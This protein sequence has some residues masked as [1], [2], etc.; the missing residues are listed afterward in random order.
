[1]YSA[2]RVA[3]IAA[4]INPHR[5]YS[6]SLQSAE[7]CS[8]SAFDEAMTDQQM[9]CFRQNGLLE[10]TYPD[11]RSLLEDSKGIPMLNYLLSTRER[12]EAF[13]QFLAYCVTDIPLDDRIILQEYL[14]MVCMLPELDN[15]SIRTM[16]GIY[17]K[18]CSS[19]INCSPFKLRNLLMFYGLATDIFGKCIINESVRYAAQEVLKA[20]NPTLYNVLHEKMNH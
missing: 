1:V 5:V 3:V 9:I 12:G 7:Q 10:E 8:L 20:D 19:E 4:L 11:S 13:S 6:P 14:N 2:R 16:V 17:A 15:A 18:H